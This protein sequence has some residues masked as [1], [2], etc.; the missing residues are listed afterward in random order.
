MTLDLFADCLAKGNASLLDIINRQGVV[1]QSTIINKWQCRHTW[2]FHLTQSDAY[3]DLSQ[4]SLHCWA[5]G[6][7][8]VYPNGQSAQGSRVPQGIPQP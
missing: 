7:Y 1:L 3:S 6:A 2:L 5:R 8:L 4:L